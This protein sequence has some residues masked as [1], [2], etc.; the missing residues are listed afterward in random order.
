MMPWREQFGLLGR[1]VLWLFFPIRQ[2]KLWGVMVFYV[3]SASSIIGVL[4]GT[5][6][7]FLCSCLVMIPSSWMSS[8]GS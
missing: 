7:P 2:F 6:W 3:L 5:W 1:C 4:R 8:R